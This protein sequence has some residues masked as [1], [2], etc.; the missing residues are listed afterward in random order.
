MPSSNN[1]RQRRLEPQPGEAIDRSD[2]VEF[3]FDGRRVQGFRGDTVASALCAAGTRVFSRSFK[4]HRPRGLLCCAAACPNCLVSVGGEPNVR[5]CARAVEPGLQVRSQN[6][7]PSLGFDLL[8]LLDRLHWLMP[9]GFYYKALHR[10]KALWLLARRVIRRVGGLGSIDVNATYPPEFS[11]RNL[12]VDVAVV[13]GGPAGIAAALAAA[14]AG[15]SVAMI[16]DQPKL[17]GHLRFSRQP[18]NTPGGGES[19]PACELAQ[20][21]AETIARSPN[22]ETFSN[23]TTFGLYQGNLVAVLTNEGLIRVRAKQV[24]LATGACEA[25]LLFENNDLPGVMLTSAARRLVTLYG[26]RPGREAVVA[27]ESPDGGDDAYETALE[28]LDAGVRVAAVVD[29][30]ETASGEA[31]EAVRVRGV[32]IL[33]GHRV[34]RAA[35]RGRVKSVL[36]APVGGSDLSAAS[37]I[38]CDLLCMSGPSQPVDALLHQADA[39]RPG[40]TLAGG[41]NGARG[42]DEINRQG[43]DAG[44]RATSASIGNSPSLLEDAPP[45]DPA[46]STLPAVPTGKGA[47]TYLCFCEDVSVHDIEQA[48][49]EGFADVQ[50]L[51]RYTAATMGPC[52]GKMCGSALAGICAA[53]AGATIPSS[54]LHGQSGGEEL[55]QHTGQQM[56]GIRP[57]FHTGD[58]FTTSR[59]P[60]Q[61]VPLAVLAGRERI[62]L[63]R[64]SLDRIHR[65][66]GAAMVESGPWQRPHSYG[67]PADECA[68]VRERVG[69]IDVGTLGKLEVLGRDAPHLLDR[70]YTHRFSDLPVGRIRYG[71]MTSD[72]GVILDDGTVTRLAADRYFVTTTSGNADLIEEWFNWWNP[73]PKAEGANGTTNC[74]HVVNVTAAYGAVNVAGPRAR[75]TLSKLTELDLSNDGF[76]YMR[77]AQCEV[78]GVP[79][80][81][82]RIGFV[83]ETGWEVHFPAEY[84]EHMWHA[85]MEAGRDFGIAPFGLEAQRILRL[86]KGHIIVGQDTDATSTPLNAGSEWAVRFDKDD[87]I[88][89]DGLAIA[90]ARGPQEQL[91]GFVMPNADAPED[92]TPV[93]SSGRPVGRVTSARISPTLGTGFGLAWVPPHLAE[94]GAT[95]EVLIDHR[96]VTARITLQPVYDPEGRRLRG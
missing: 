36:V 72:N 52:Q 6:A 38:Q 71:L 17:G 18:V 41:V 62:P 32:T 66:L 44:A 63:K 81:L 4:Y 68:A 58:Y 67:S 88:G 92:G 48:I 7:W 33:T 28:L 86:E 76:R 51:K 82:L 40:V 78:A 47:R 89:R 31:V 80:L 12:H 45:L 13:G 21:L 73:P 87:F 25:P 57:G 15:A 90:A 43:W 95:V 46:T 93:L 74:T 84:G 23:A 34:V 27:I 53:H 94:D 42:L 91:V 49:G 35:G 79:C 2:P 56:E 39:S 20:E 3:E 65:E 55:S 30:S 11:S 50:I 10:P 26:V 1:S 16:D 64:T 5:A 19:R 29:A 8:S 60:Y 14:G 70:L 59:P 75:E 85:I 9:V 22:I 69:I 54:L 96:P 37:K 24:T 61:P 77:S 83:G